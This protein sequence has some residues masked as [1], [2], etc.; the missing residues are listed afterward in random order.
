MNQLCLDIAEEKT[1]SGSKVVQWD[2]T[3]N[4]NQQWVPVPAGAGVW[5]LRSVH[6]PSAYLSIKDD[7]VNDGGKL[8]ISDGD[9]PSQYWRI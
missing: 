3:G 9:S 7:N 2:K 8:Q 4:A 1:E 6:A 5:K